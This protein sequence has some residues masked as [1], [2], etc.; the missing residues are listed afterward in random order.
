MPD[1]IA[2]LDDIVQVTGSS[3]AFAALRKNGTVVAWGNATVGGDTTSVVG[4]LTQVQALYSNTHG[5]VAL[6][7]DGRVVTWGHPDGGGDSS[8]KQDKLEGQV[9][10][11]ANSASRGLALKANRLAGLVR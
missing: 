9:S 2:T 3:M 7:A 8:A 6:T 10:Y 11:T 4:E 5:F 1:D